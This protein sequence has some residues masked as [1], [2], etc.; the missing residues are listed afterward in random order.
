M[1]GRRRDHPNKFTVKNSSKSEDILIELVVVD[2]GFHGA[3][4]A[5]WIATPPDEQEQE[6]SE[7]DGGKPRC[8]LHNFSSEGH[9][10]DHKPVMHDLLTQR[11]TA[12]LGPARGAH[13][14][15]GRSRMVKRKLGWPVWLG[16]ESMMLMNDDHVWD[17]RAAKAYDTPGTG[18][19]A[20]EV[21]DPAVD[22]LAELAHGGRCLELAIGTGRVAIALLERGVEVSGIELSQPM[23]D[24]LRE[25]IGADRLPVL[26]GD[27]STARINGLFDVVYVVFNSISCLLTQ[28]A[29]AACVRNAA[30]H[31][32]PNGCFVVELFVPDL[33][34][35]TPGKTASTFVSEPG[36][37]GLDTWEAATQHV[38]SHHFRFAPE[39]GEDRRAHVFRSPH[40]YI[41]PS[42]LDLMAQLAGLELES[43]HADW[44]KTPFDNDSRDHIS[45]YRQPS[46]S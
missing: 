16:S 1:C 29:Q 45:V 3:S 35:L 44:R 20:P 15:K 4:V 22:R 39:I 40:R 32:A 12:R 21:L 41:W 13:E 11:S 46:H 25:K 37:I 23:I 34:S 28:A 2:G 26:C 27:M 33:R 38:V 6:F 14:R 9:E 5:V 42:E 17:E 30:N 31:L 8:E 36:Y 19:F 43:R 18:M 10:S 24:R 7:F